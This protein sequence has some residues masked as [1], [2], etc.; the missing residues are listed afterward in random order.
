MTQQNAVPLVSICVTTFNHAPYIKDALDSMLDQQTTFPYEI[1][2]HDDASTDGTKQILEE[3]EERFPNRIRVFYES[4]NQ[5]GKGTYVG[6]YNRGLLV[7]NAKGKYIA[8]CEGDDCWSD[9]KKLQLQISYMEERPEVS[10]C[11]HAASRVDGVS[12]KYISTMG[13]GSLE[14]DLTTSEIILNWSVPTASW[15]YRK[16][17]IDS[18]DSEWQ[19]D[20]PAGDFPSVL[21][22]SIIGR[23]HYIPKT[24]S[25]YRYRVPGSY[26]SELQSE[27]KLISI[28]NRWLEMLENLDNA[29]GNRWHR[30]FLTMAAGYIKNLVVIE[31][32]SMCKTSFSQEV[33]DSLSVTN[34]IKLRVLRALHMLG[35]QI[36]WRNV[37][38]GNKAIPVLCKCR[39]K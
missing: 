20:M 16:G 10:L 30:E 33:F 34:R 24:M 5:W 23:V 7:P 28:S 36:C 13:M 4:V 15:V 35:L 3:Y 21:Y 29:T 38:G 18:L 25:I 26:T 19:F 32:F 14:H 6:G 11:C 1:L 2:V 8:I 22:A 31:G 17:T 39:K 12:G 9:Q 27:D 37:G